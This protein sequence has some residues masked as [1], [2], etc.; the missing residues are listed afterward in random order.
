MNIDTD[1]T[2]RY[3]KVNKNLI[4]LNFHSYFRT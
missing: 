1:Y 4:F 3:Y 2:T